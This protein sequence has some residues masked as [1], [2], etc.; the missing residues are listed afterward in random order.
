MIILNA[1]YKKPENES[2]F[3]DYYNKTH[4]PLVMKVPGLFKA[5]AELVTKTFMGDPDDFYMIARMYY[6]DKETFGK[7]MRSPENQATGKDLANFSQSG[8][9]LFITESVD[10]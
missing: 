7:A 8:V 9:S 3:Q 2:A 1:L 5:E 10:N 4:M 6:E